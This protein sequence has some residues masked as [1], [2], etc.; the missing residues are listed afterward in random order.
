MNMYESL[1]ELCF[2]LGYDEVTDLEVTPEG[3]Y[4]VL[5]KDISIVDVMRRIREDYYYKKLIRRATFN[6]LVLMEKQFINGQWNYVMIRFNPDNFG[7]S[8]VASILAVPYFSEFGDNINV[9]SRQIYDA[10]RREELTE[11]I[12]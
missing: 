1:K 11:I 9:E 12:D 3:E 6:S 10:L 5:I 7:V 2:D 4:E 8:V